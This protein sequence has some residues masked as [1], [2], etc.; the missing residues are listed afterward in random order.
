MSGSRMRRVVGLFIFCVAGLLTGA[1]A[2]SLTAYPSGV[3][4]KAYCEEDECEMGTYCQ[5]NPGQTT[6]CDEK[7]TFECVTYGCN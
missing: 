7:P 3:V 2:G 1:L 5:D 6:G 4:A